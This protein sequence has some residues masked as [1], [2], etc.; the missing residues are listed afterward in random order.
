MSTIGERL[1][2]A[3]EKRGQDLEEVHLEIKISPQVLNA[4]EEDRAED[5]VGI[6]YAK[7]FLRQYANYLGL[8]GDKLA[9]ELEEKRP[10]PSE[11]IKPVGLTLER[12]KLSKST[13]LKNISILILIV[14]ILGS[15]LIGIF[16]FAKR[17]KTGIPQR[18]KE[19]AVE[20][21]PHTSLFPI[22][23]NQKIKLTLTAYD[24]VWV[25]V[26][27][28]G[29]TVNKNILKKGSRET[30]QADENIKII[31][32]KPEAVSLELNG[33]PFRLPKGRKIKP[34]TITRQG[35]KF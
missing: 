7:T 16:H 21:L 29:T 3:R 31:I 34:L 33:K 1:K 17:T 22:P 32:G 14:A 13:I 30:W 28:D 9:K 15:M 6:V 4:L 24:N 2:S 23:E 19:K 26:E 5:L 11:D 35:Y 18:P 12:P 8:D 20:S 27:S 10:T 25:E